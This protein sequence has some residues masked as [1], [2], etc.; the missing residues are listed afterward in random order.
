MV[1]FSLTQWI[2]SLDRETAILIHNTI[3]YR[4]YQ[5][6]STNRDH[7]DMALTLGTAGSSLC[8]QCDIWFKEPKT[9]VHETA[10]RRLLSLRDGIKNLAM[11]M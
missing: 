11:R 4:R 8:F 1:K 5:H 3:T 10:F 7:T 9:R 6:G 2:L